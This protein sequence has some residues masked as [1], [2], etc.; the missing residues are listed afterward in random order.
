MNVSCVAPLTSRPQDHAGYL[1]AG[2]NTSLGKKSSLR[3]ESVHRNVTD[4]LMA[5]LLAPDCRRDSDCTL[6]SRANH[7]LALK[8]KF[9]SAN[10]TMS[11]Q[12]QGVQDLADNRSLLLNHV[13][14]QQ[15]YEFQNPSWHRHKVQFKQDHLRWMRFR[16]AK[17][18]AG[19]AL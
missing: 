10:R 17:S 15:R 7:A 5:Q 4:A 6:N 13:L 3:K 16:L 1:D 19:S 18:H 9:C 14:Q 2:S 8:E 12:P 11:D